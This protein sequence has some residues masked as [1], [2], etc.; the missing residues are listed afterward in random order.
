MLPG[1]VRFDVVSVA[2]PR[3]GVGRIDVVVPLVG[4]A[5]LDGVSFS[6]AGVTLGLGV[7]RRLCDVPVVLGVKS[8]LAG[9]TDVLDE[10]GLL[11]V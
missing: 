3:E 11:G 7:G 6:F 1:V 10:A 2:G 8:C 9:D 5:D 4:D